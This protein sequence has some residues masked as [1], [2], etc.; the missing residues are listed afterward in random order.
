[1][2]L[3]LVLEDT[4][5]DLRRAAD[6]A[7]RAGFT[8]FEVHTYSSAAQ[9]YLDKAMRRMVPMPDAMVIDLELGIESGFELLRF[10]HSTPKLRPIPVIIWTVS[11]AHQREIC[12]LFKVYRFVSKED[13]PGVLMETLASIIQNP[14]A[15]SPSPSVPD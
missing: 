2:P 7:R 6:I 8:E 1:M 10:W 15:S 5:A 11:G 12:E 4:P 13:D 3:L 14:P 9:V